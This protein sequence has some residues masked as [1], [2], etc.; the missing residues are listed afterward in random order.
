M[1]TR[2][3]T[4]SPAPDSLSYMAWRCAPEL[5]RRALYSVYL[6]WLSGGE[7]PPEFN[8]AFLA[9]LPK[10]EGATIAAGDTRPLSL[11]NCDAKLWHRP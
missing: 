5:P 6:R 9:L 8:W 10:R 11:T 2:S 7:L 4:T 1:V 3:K